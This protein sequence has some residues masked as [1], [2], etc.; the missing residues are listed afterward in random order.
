MLTGL[1]HHSSSRH[2]HR[3]SLPAVQ[4]QV[5]IDAERFALL[6]S[7]SFHSDALGTFWMPQLHFL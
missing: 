3:A 4:Q 6:R 2:G 1:K 7:L 5:T